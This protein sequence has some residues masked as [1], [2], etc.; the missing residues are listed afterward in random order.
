[1]EMMLHETKVWGVQ[2]AL[3]FS[4]HLT[5][6]AHPF[7]RK[8]IEEKQKNENFKHIEVQIRLDRLLRICNEIEK[9]T[10]LK[11]LRAQG[12]LYNNLYETEGFIFIK[13]KLK[14]KKLIIVFTTIF[15]NFGVS[16]LVIISMLMKYGSSILLLKNDDYSHYLNGVKG[17][18]NDLDQVSLSIK[19]LIKKES[20][21][22]I[23]IMG[24][25]SGGF[26]SCFVSGQIPCTSY[27][28]FSIV[29]DFSINSPL[30][31]NL[32][33]KENIRAQFPKKYLINLRDLVTKNSETKR[34]FI[35]GNLS[36]V[37]LLFAENL[38]DLS[39]TEISYVE[40]SFHA[41]PLDLIASGK[42]MQHLD[43]AFE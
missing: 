37:D 21:N 1:M 43:W 8:F 42:M 19:T 2:E 4:E 14:P 35:V 41:T 25:S 20:I 33:I 17:F 15:N 36:H 40:N 12:T 5:A 39:N 10:Q 26:A 18:G 22:N 16:N 32:I 3:L 24:Y 11:T 34:R 13:S 38:R 28:G 9:L 7:A 29:S 23:S 6:H 30:P 27:L 31:V